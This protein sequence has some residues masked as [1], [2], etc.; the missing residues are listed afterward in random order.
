MKRMKFKGN[1]AIVSAI[2]SHVLSWVAFLWLMF[3]PY[4]YQG[5]QTVPT[6][7]GGPPGLSTKTHASLLAA[8][9]LWAIVPL[10]VPVI[11]TALLLTIAISKRSKKVVKLTAWPLAAMLLGFCVLGAFSI[12]MFYLPAALA[13]GVTAFMLLRRKP[14]VA[15]HQ[16]TVQVRGIN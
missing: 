6:V 12:G 1:A 9:G 4:F 2:A 11:I 15:D 13:A 8:N 7:P 3:W 5:L 16:G 10:L 14:E